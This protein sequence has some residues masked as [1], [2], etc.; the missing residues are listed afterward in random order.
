MRPDYTRIT[1]D[2]TLHFAQELSRLNPGMVFDYV[3]GV[4]P[5]APKKENHVG[6][7]QRQN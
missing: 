6:P 1:Y 5:T 4:T 3:S 2:T 7:R